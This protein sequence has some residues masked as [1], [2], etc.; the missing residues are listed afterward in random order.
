MMDICLVKSASTSVVC[1]LVTKQIAKQILGNWKI[2]LGTFA[3]E[4][5]L[6]DL[7][8]GEPGSSGW[9]NRLAGSGGPGGA[10]HLCLVFKILS[11]NSSR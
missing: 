7:R 3:W 10:R 2:R 9:G 6:Q 1:S 11:K 8:L 4:L 5:L